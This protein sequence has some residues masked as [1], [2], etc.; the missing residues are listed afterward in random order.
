VRVG[1]STTGVS[2]RHLRTLYQ[3]EPCWNWTSLYVGHVQPRGYRNYWHDRRR[4][5]FHLTPVHFERHHECWEFGVC[6]G[7]R[8]LFV[9]R[10]R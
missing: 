8:T 9:K 6:W 7:R 5:Q 3:G 10:H 4:W 2:T 1:V